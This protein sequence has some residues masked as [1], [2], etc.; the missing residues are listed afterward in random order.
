MFQVVARHWELIFCILSNTKCELDEVAKVSFQ[1]FAC[2]SELIF[3][4]LT[5]PKCD[6]VEVEKAMFQVLA[7][8]SQVI[9]DLWT[10]PKCHLDEVE[11]AM[12]QHVELSYY[13]RFIPRFSTIASP[14]HK[15]LKKDVKYKWK[16]ALE[17]AF[18]SLQSRL[19]SS[20]FE[21]TRLNP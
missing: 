12:I 14:L 18:R 4:L 19:V 21:I 1:R 3:G 2:H 10:S 9:L 20:Y 8:H 5:N 11:K 15:L 7:W 16:E 6:L 17:H 13:R